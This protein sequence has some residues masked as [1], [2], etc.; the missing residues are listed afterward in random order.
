VRV[1]KSPLAAPCRRSS[2]EEHG[3]DDRDVKVQVKTRLL[4]RDRR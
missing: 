2:L 3:R 1:A 4:P